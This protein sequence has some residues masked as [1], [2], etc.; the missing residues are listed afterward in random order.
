MRTASTLAVT[1]AAIAACGDPSD[2]ARPAFQT[3]ALPRNYAAIDLGTLG[4]PPQ[5]RARH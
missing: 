1:L 4:G 2:P 5:H 3:E